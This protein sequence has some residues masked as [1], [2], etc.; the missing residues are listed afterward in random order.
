[1]RLF[2]ALE[3]PDRVRSA[4]SS[5]VGPL[6]DRHERLN[7]TPREQWHLTVAFLGPVDDGRLGDVA[8]VLASAGSEAA[9][10][11][12]LALGAAGHFGRR[13]LWLRVHDE[14]DG[15]VRDL[16]ERTQRALVAA[17]LPCDEKP[18]RPHVTLARP[19]ERSGKLPS[20]VVEAVPEAEAAWDVEELLLYE[21]RRG[22]HR[23]PNVHAVV[24]RF[25]LGGG[26]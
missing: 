5:A 1:M 12:G 19:R 22:G 25:P 26:T 7:W 10:R 24:E 20:G 9:G 2:A 13:V 21:S 8:E 15:A 17:G 6:R 16:G 18:V 11:I 23:Q 4:I 3:V 14:P